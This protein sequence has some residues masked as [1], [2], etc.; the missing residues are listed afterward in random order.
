M[1]GADV[2]RVCRAPHAFGGGDDPA[3]GVCADCFSAR[4]EEI[5]TE[6]TI[7]VR[8]THDHE[9]AISW[10]RDQL[11]QLGCMPAFVEGHIAR[12]T[13][14]DTLALSWQQVRG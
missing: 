10:L 6:F 4:T 13:V 8:A 2:C 7:L 14:A 12:I 1:S 3:P 5:G 11:L 9:Q